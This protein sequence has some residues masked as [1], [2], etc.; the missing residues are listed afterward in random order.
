[1]IGISITAVNIPEKV[2]KRCYKSIVDAKWVSFAGD[3]WEM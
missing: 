2:I 1:M 3:A